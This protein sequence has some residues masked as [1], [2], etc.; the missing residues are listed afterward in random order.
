[1]HLYKEMINNNMDENNKTPNYL[2]KTDDGSTTLFIEEYEQ[3]MHSTSGAYEESL[4]KHLLPSG[5]LNEKTRTVNILD[6][7]FGLGYNILALVQE[8]CEN[9]K[10]NPINIISIEKERTFIP[11]MDKIKFNDKKDITYELVKEAYSKGEAKKTG[12]N[13]LVKFGDAREIIQ[14]LEAETFDAVFQDPFSPSKNPELWSLEYFK[15][16]YTLMKKTGILTTYSSA[17]QI[18]RA[19][20]EAGFYI[21][22]GPSVGKKREGT[23]ASPAPLGK[24]LLPEDLTAIYNDPRSIPYRDKNLSLKRESILQERLLEIK[25]MKNLIK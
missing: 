20:L 3:A 17:N 6:I 21:G 24:K 9:K 25:E 8:Y 13:I 2:M 18:R 7:G 16:I 10:S 22:K 23:V 4:L 19:M 15:K 11:F 1:M 5:I 14:T 12:I